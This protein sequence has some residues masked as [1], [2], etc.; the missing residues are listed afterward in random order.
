MRK[1]IPFFLSLALTCSS[2][3]LQAE[4][5]VC[6]KCVRIREDNKKKVNPYEYY[7]DY[8]KANGKEISSSTEVGLSQK[9]NKKE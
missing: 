5:R 8:L 3:V 7:E 4:E 2:L 9:E 1:N 6:P